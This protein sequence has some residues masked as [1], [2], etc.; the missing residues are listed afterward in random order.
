MTSSVCEREEGV[1][2]TQSQGGLFDVPHRLLC[3]TPL[4]FHQSLKGPP[5]QVNSSHVTEGMEADR[6]STVL[7]R[8][9]SH[10]CASLSTV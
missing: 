9:V 2:N 10:F 3:N 4:L 6:R 7:S 5:T 8:S 1:K